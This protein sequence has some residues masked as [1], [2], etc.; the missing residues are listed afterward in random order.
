MEGAY[1]QW[2]QDFNEDVAA[3]RIVQVGNTPD[4]RPIWRWN[5]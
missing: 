2:I 4:G 3:G 1:V 5:A